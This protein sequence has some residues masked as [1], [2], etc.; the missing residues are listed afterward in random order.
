ML[1][2][3]CDIGSNTVKYGIYDCKEKNKLPSG[4]YFESKTVKLISHI[5]NGVLEECT[6]NALAELCSSYKASAQKH[7]A[8][9]FDIFATQCI[10]LA[11]N[12]EYICNKIKEATGVCTDI[13]SGADEARFSRLA[14][15]YES[16]EIKKG[17]C[18]DMGGGSSEIV[19][20]DENKICACKSLP[21][22]C[23]VLKNM[24]VKAAFPNDFE[25]NKIKEYVGS[26]IKDMD[27]SN[28]SDSFCLIGGTAKAIEALYITKFHEPLS[29]SN[30]NSLFNFLRSDEAVKIIKDKIPERIE[31]VLPGLCAFIAVCDKIKPK[32]VTVIKS[33]TREGYLM[34]KYL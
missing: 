4:I 27:F 32:K 19:L 5:E 1:R 29:Y 18:V 11:E 26:F 6:V 9:S 2:A 34:N 24:F 17:I 13:L 8:V 10:R 22:G 20:F 14:M 12:R 30:L 33:G 3:V 28:F 25:V 15:Q 31:T 23:L 21:F 16:P 7:S